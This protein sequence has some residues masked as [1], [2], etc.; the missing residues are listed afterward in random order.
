MRPEENDEQQMETW[1][2]LLDVLREAR[3]LLALPGNDFA[4]SSW[5]DVSTAVAEMDRHIMAVEGGQLPTLLDLAVLFAP[6][7]PMQEVSLSSGWGHEFLTVAARF[8]V[9]TK[10]AYSNR[11][12]NDLEDWIRSVLRR[13]ADG[14]LLPIGYFAGLDCNA[15]LDSR[16]RDKEFE[17]SWLR[18][19]EEVDRR[20]THAN[21]T[22]HLRAFAEDIRRE[23]FLAV[24]LATG[25]HEIASY[26]SEDF[27]LLVRGRLM[28]LNEPLLEQLWRAYDDGKF[29]SPPA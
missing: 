9:A 13:I 26:V 23:S 11:E 18:L 14:T 17:T 28:G 4:W 24:S 27:D 20:W 22:E 19:H 2:E 15:A 21:V 16:D 1:H 3:A 29:P 10:R 25:Q 8:D 5:K 7:G 6:T 12:A